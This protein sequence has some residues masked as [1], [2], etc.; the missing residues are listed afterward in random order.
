M[1]FSI[2]VCAY[3]EEK[4]IERCLKSLI[5]INFSTDDFEVLVINDGSSDKTKLITESFIKK[6]NIINFKHIEIEHAGLSI[7][8]NAGIDN[9]NFDI[10]I[11][12]DADAI[13]DKNILIE[14]SK[15]Y[16]NEEV[17]FSGGAISLLNTD[18]KVAHFFQITR[19]KQNFDENNY[20]EQL[21][22]A[23]MSFKKRLF[24]EDGGFPNIFVSRCDDTFIRERFINKYCYKPSPFAI[25]Q[26]ERPSNFFDCIKIFYQEAKNGVIMNDIF[27]KNSFQNKIFKLLLYSLAIFIILIIPKIAIFFISLF[28]TKSLRNSYKTL[29]KND[30]LFSIILGYTTI[31]IFERIIKE[32]VFIQKFCSKKPSYNRDLK[33]YSIANK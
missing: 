29:D 18:S 14:Y 2:I 5:K 3:N 24:Y 22:G 9:S 13:V 31:K 16:S 10:I 20:K 1:K 4:V 30:R 19:F 15:T 7:A 27:E 17:E 25:V 32:I 23:N 28:L 33:N 8:R 11:F 21:I 6:N 26:H 12:I